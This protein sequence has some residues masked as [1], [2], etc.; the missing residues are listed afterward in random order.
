MSFR[1]LY[2]HGFARVAACTIRSTL[3][4][5]AANAE[6][7]LRMAR[8][9]HQQAVALAVFPELVL[10]GYAIEDL[11][12]QDTLLDAAARAVETIV[13]ESADLLPLLLIGAPLRHAGRVYNTA[14]AI[15]RGRLL[16]V[17]PKIH[18]PNYREFYEPRHFASG[19]GQQGRGDPH[20]RAY[21]SLRHRSDLRGR[22]CDRSR[23][24]CGDLRGFLGAR[25]AQRRSGAGRRDRACQSF[26]EQHHDREGRDKAAAVPIAIR[27]LPRGLS[28]RR[29]RNGGVDDRSCLG[30]SGRR[31]SRWGRRSPKP[32]DSRPPT[33]WPSRM[34][35][36]ICCGRNGAQQTTFDDNRR[37]RER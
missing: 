2:R 19:R 18:L 27:P 37:W 3:A 21:G 9:C 13:T 12:L 7:V 17:V 29:R 32:S 6:A 4:D 24:S 35:I 14:L 30:W 26:R 34:S 8:D 20:R 23:R 15:H 25:A 33:R 16:G 1:S 28:L 36:S 11:L 5:P 22:G 10:S 31:S